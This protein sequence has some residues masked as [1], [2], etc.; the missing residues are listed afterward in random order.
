[1]REKNVWTK[2]LGLGLGVGIGNTIRRTADK[3]YESGKGGEIEAARG[4][5][6]LIL[7][8]WD[9]NLVRNFFNISVY[10][11]LMNNG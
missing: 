1:M 9:F 6:L 10:H 8:L 3:I 2:G 7:I 5:R 4:E 11:Q